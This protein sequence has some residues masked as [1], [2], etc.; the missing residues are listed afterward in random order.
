MQYQNL[1][2]LLK[3]ESNKPSKFKT[4]N[5]IEINNEARVTYS[6]NKQI[7]FKITLLR[8]GLCDYSDAY[9]LVKGNITVNNT[10]DAGAAATNTN[11]EI[12]FKNCDPFASCFSKINH[13]QIDD[14]KCIDIV[15]PMYNLIEYRDNYSKTSGSLWQYYREILAVNNNGDIDDFNGVNATDLFNS[16]GMVCKLCYNLHRYC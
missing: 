6:S 12:T 8:S 2:N 11:K 7:K 9:I 15:M 13:T 10:A 4:R 16:F 1:S 14:A 5:W 3:D